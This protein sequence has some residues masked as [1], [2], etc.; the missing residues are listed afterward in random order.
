MVKD[1]G[2]R[3]ALDHWDGHTP[4]EL[5]RIVYVGASRAEQLLVLAVHE[6]HLERVSGL[7]ER[8]ARVQP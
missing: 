5:R 7:L 2:D 3:H 6:T 4:S 8:D 1:D